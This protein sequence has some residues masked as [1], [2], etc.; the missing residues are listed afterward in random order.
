MEGVWVTII[1]KFFLNSPNQR[2]VNYYLIA[3]VC[4]NINQGNMISRY[5]Q[6]TPDWIVRLGLLKHMFTRSEKT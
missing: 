6:Y 4:P 5:P 2:E 1:K 3:E